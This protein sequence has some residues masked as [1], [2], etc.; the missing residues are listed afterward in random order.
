[1]KPQKQCNKPNCKVLID[2]DKRYCANHEKVQASNQRL[3]RKQSEGKYFKFYESRTWR[4]ASYLYRLRH[5]CCEDCLLEG[6][7]RKAD[8]VD[9]MVELKDD[10]NR[11]LDENNFRSLCHSHHN[12]KTANERQRRENN[13]L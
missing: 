8:V 12:S 9:H 6:T 4:K 2:Y 7:V 13:T 5:P 11:R 1:M 3:E 10:W